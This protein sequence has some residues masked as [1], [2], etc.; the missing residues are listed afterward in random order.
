[1]EFLE[2]IVVGYIVGWVG[3]GKLNARFF[4]LGGEFAACT[5]FF[6]VF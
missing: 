6:L 1:M 3:R 5:Y 4:G 2:V